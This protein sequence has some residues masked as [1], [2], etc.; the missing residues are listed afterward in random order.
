MR[1]GLNCVPPT[2]SAGQPAG[3]AR[4]IIDIP[5]LVGVPGRTGPLSP[6]TC[7]V[8]VWLADEKGDDLD[9]GFTPGR[10]LRVDSREG[11]TGDDALV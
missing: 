6:Q 10:V 5:G 3:A 9:C 11:C 2:G 1:W 4:L 7:G 8:L